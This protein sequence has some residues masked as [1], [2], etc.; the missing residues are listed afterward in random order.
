MGYLH[1]IIEFN[2]LSEPKTLLTEVCIAIPD[3]KLSNKQMQIEC[4]S[5]SEQEKNVKMFYIFIWNIVLMPQGLNANKFH[6]GGIFLVWMSRQNLCAPFPPAVPELILSTSAREPQGPGCGREEDLCRRR[7]HI[8]HIPSIIFTKLLTTYVYSDTWSLGR[9][10]FLK[11]IYLLYLNKHFESSQKLFNIPVY[12][13][14][15]HRIK[16]N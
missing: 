5:D 13:T 4:F 8:I 7:G 6:V 10:R 12:S 15:I 11:K 14:C 1:A 2:C 16:L 9:M 3:R